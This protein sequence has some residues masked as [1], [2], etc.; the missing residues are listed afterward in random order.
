M[1]QFSEPIAKVIHGYRNNVAWGDWKEV[2]KVN[3]VAKL[4]KGCCPVCNA[5]IKWEKI[6]RS[7]WLGDYIPLQAGYFIGK[8][9]EP[10]P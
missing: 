8:H 9:K 4:E 2:R 7:M 10:D 1:R 3:A 6:R 5:K